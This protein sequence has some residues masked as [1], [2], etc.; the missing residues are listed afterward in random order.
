VSDQSRLPETPGE[1]MRRQARRPVTGQNFQSPLERMTGVESVLAEQARQL[2]SI[3]REHVEVM[4]RL[5]DALNRSAAAQEA[6]NALN[7]EAWKRYGETD[8]AGDEWKAGGD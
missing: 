4:R 2:E 1:F 6:A 5:T 3:T 8:Q 7:A